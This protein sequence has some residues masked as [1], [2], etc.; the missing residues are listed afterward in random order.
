VRLFDAHRIGR[1]DYLASER[2]G[3]RRCL[4]REEC[5]VTAGRR[6]LAAVGKIRPMCRAVREAF[7]AAARIALIGVQ[8]RSKDQQAGSRAPGRL[9]PGP[10]RSGV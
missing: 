8:S 1:H 6:M 7:S 10:Q 5:L 9:R 4:S 2:K 3:G